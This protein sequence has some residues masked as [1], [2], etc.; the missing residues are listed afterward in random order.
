MLNFSKFWNIYFSCDV[1]ISK[2][3]NEHPNFYIM[4]IAWDKNRNQYLVELW[5]EKFWLQFWLRGDVIN[6]E[7]GQKGPRLV[8]HKPI[9]VE[10]LKSIVKGSLS[11]SISLWND[12]LKMLK[13]WLCFV[14]SP[15]QKW[16][17]ID[18]IGI[19][20][21]NVDRKMK[22]INK[23]YFDVNYSFMKP[24]SQNFEVLTPFVTLSTQNWLKKGPNSYLMY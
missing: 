7:L 10:R 13:I 18:Q 16:V 17:K 5:I 12:Y 23:R 8:F 22:I 15:R 9:V 1:I 11:R 2:L 21:T 19:S 6:P 20:C 4:Y 3:Y 24:S 14:V